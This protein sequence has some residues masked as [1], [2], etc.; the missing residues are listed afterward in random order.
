MTPLLC[1]LLS[2]LITTI[3]SKDYTGYKLFKVN[4][5]D[6]VLQFI[7]SFNIYE[8]NGVDIMLINRNVTH[9]L[10]SPHVQMEFGAL[11]QQL[12]ATY[13]IDNNI[14]RKIDAEQLRRRTGRHGFHEKQFFDAIRPL[15]EIQSFVS[16]LVREH[17]NV[18]KLKSIGKTYEGNDIE[19]VVIS[20]S[21]EA[22]PKLI[23]IEAGLHAREWIA[24][25][26]AL[27]FLENIVENFHNFSEILRDVEINIVPVAN[28]D[29]YKH[30]FTTDRLWRKNRQ[31]NKGSTCIGVDLNRNFGF[32]WGETGT[33]ADPCSES[34]GG[35]RAFSGLESTYIA[36]YLIANMK[37]LVS[38]V[39]L[40]SY[41][42]DIFYPYGNTY[43]NK[44]YMH[45]TAQRIE[46]AISKI[47]GTKYE[48]GTAADLIYESSGG[49]DDYAAG[50]LGVPLTFTI[51]LPH[52]DFIIPA[53]EVEPIGNETTEGLIELLR[54]VA[55]Y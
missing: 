40:H 20:D 25:A 44:D 42:K 37:R 49:V 29:G 8:L 33:S 55:D 7:E 38:F 5:T 22:K 54:I 26:T 50:V 16:K 6:N 4:N 30:T 45:T 48:I 43:L 51:E 18:A 32:H 13:T 15:K 27:Y 39:D 34:Y 11:L 3:H 21:S 53:E 46:S 24:P 23:F 10:V 17:A 31:P 47:R 14:Q 35:D 41:G 9:A 36:R 19:M 2:V 52:D 1:A 28:P 12:N